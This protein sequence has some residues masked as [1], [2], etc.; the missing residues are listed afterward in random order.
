MG[1]GS[2]DSEHSQGK[3]QFAAQ[4]SY[5]ND[6]RER[7][8]QSNHLYF[9]AGRLDFFFRAFGKP[10]CLDCKRLGKLSAA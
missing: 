3:Q 4:F 6:I 1:A 5:P 9:S 2:E 7:R 10:V 8:N